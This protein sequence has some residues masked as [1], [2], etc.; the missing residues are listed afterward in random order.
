M[1]QY[2]IYECEKC[3]KKSKD[4]TEII[5]CEAA[6]LNLSEEEYRQWE[7]LKQN[8]RYASHIV[9]TCKNEQTDKEF[10]EA[11]AELM[12]FEKSHGIEENQT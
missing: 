3:G 7:E 12:E 2:T 9:S 4:K 11:I 6:H 8:V 5:K 1:K 10:D